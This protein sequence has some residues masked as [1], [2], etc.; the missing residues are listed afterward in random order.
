MMVSHNLV[1][2]QNQAASEVP[3]IIGNTNPKGVLGAEEHIVNEPVHSNQVTNEVMSPLSSEFQSNSQQNHIILA[4]LASSPSSVTANSFPYE[5]KPSGLLQTEEQIINEPYS[6]QVTNDV[7]SPLPSKF[8]QSTSQQT[9]TILADES[10]NRLASSPSVTANS[11]PPQSEILATAPDHH[12]TRTRIIGRKRQYN[13]SNEAYGPWTNITMNDGE[14]ENSI[15]LSRG[16]RLVFRANVL[17]PDERSTLTDTMQNC[18]LFRQYSF[19]ETY[20]EPRSHVLLS[21]KIKSDEKDNANSQVQPG[22]VYHGICM[23]AFPLDQVP[24][25]ERLANRLAGSYGIS[26]WNTGVDMIAYKDGEDRIGWHADDT[27]GEALIVCVVVSSPEPRPLHIRPKKSANRPLRTGDE[28]IEIYPSEGDG[29]DMDDIMQHGYEHSLPKKSKNTSHRFAIVLRNGEEGNVIEDSGVEIIKMSPPTHFSTQ[30]LNQIQYAPNTELDTISLMKKIRYKHAPVTFGPAECLEEGNCYDRRHLYKTFA[31]R[32]DQKGIN[33]N[34][35]IGS[36]SIVVSRQ[37]KDLREDDGLEWLFYTSTRMQGALGLCRSHENNSPIRVFRSSRLENQYSPP[38]FTSE[39][40]QERT[41]YRY[42]GLYLVCKVFDSDGNATEV[43]PIGNEQF[44][45]QLTRLPIQG[46]RGENKYWNQVSI[47]ELCNKIRASKPFGVVKPL[48]KP[49]CDRLDRLSNESTGNGV[50]LQPRSHVKP[51]REPN[52]PHLPDLLLN[53][54]DRYCTK[55]SLAYHQFSKQ[56]RLEQYNQACHYTNVLSWQL[57]KPYQSGYIQ[58]DLNRGLPTYPLDVF[59]P[60]CRLLQR[61]SNIPVIKKSRMSYCQPQNPID[62]LNPAALLLQLKKSSPCKTGKLPNNQ[63]VVISNQQQSATYN[64]NQRAPR[65]EK[66]QRSTKEIEEQHEIRMLTKFFKDEDRRKKQDEKNDI[67]QLIEV[68]R[69]EERD[70]KLLANIL[71][72]EERQKKREEENDMKRLIQMMK[73]EER[74]EKRSTAKLIK[75]GRMHKNDMKD[76]IKAL[77]ADAAALRQKKIEASLEALDALKS[78]QEKTKKFTLTRDTIDE[79]ESYTTQLIQRNISAMNDD[80]LPK[81]ETAMSNLILSTPTVKPSIFKSKVTTTRKRTRKSIPR[82][83]KMSS[84]GN[85]EI[86]AVQDLTEISKTVLQEAKAS[87]SITPRWAINK[88]RGIMSLIPSLSTHK[89]HKVTVVVDLKESET[90]Q[91]KSNL[92]QLKPNSNTVQ[93]ETKTS[94]TIT[95]RWE[96][97]EETGIMRLI[98]QL[99]THKYRTINVA[100]NLTSAKTKQGKERHIQQATSKSYTPQTNT[101]PVLSPYLEKLR[102]HRYQTR[103]KKSRAVQSKAKSRKKITKRPF[104]SSKK[105]TRN[106]NNQHHSTSLIVVG[107]KIEIFW[108]GE[109]TFYPGVVTKLYKKHQVCVKY[110]DGE[111]A[112][113]DLTNSTWGFCK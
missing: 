59:L 24:E 36:D 55:S 84:N 42:D 82:A 32:T 14:T 2:T 41:S 58:H 64:G 52:P 26:S 67:K 62:P 33:G 12:Q 70:I 76:L 45:F 100:M 53:K 104:W 30:R 17:S 48:P 25:V 29:Y 1:P 91:K 97:N 98:P 6:L 13:E 105:N 50:K 18:K 87:R 78:Y 68:M 8:H 113:E 69:N 56:M 83:V 27:Q 60:S 90:K 23:K 19:G 77:E 35:T 11:F 92:L 101:S 71:E 7:A 43:T 94:R 73:E 108:D 74:E 75:D 102:S 79:L 111:I 61:P 80:I 107:S 38:P 9:H 65:A 47:Y 37:S 66:D 96:T 20:A 34:K 109:R 10:D 72:D 39:N 86:D 88:E 63:G 57:S 49:D 40:N 21:S 95:P 54:A 44:T 110:D 5:H 81:L 3:L 89:Y 106:S 103:Q 31:H 46:T 4:G 93:N 85:N 112:D 28:Q 51:F 16:G 22:Y 15:E 99:S